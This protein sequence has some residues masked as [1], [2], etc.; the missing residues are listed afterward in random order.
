MKI[1]KTLFSLEIQFTIDELSQLLKVDTL[2]RNSILLAFLRIL[3]KLS[4]GGKDASTNL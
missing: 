2:T 3:D 1:K 4:K